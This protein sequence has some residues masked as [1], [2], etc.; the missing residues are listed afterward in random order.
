MIQI[1]GSLTQRSHVSGAMYL[2][3]L[4]QP[5]VSPQEPVDRG[6][7]GLGRALWRVG[8]ACLLAG[9]SSMI[10]RLYVGYRGHV[11]VQAGC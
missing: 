6:R 1:L 8:Q 11:G 5:A 3:Q 4:D 2:F 7:M 9:I 10:H